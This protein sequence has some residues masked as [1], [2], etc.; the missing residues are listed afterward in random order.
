MSYL[1][2]DA[3]MYV[4]SPIASKMDKKL[5]CIDWEVIMLQLFSQF[6]CWLEAMAFAGPL[7]MKSSS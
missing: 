5:Q 1:Q 4:G 7:Y 6:P 2:L 3:V